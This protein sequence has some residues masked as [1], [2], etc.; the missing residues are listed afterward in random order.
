MTTPAG[1]GVLGVDPGSRWTAGVLRY[2]EAALYGW[3]VGPRDAA[4][5]RDRTA[6]DDADDV[7]AVSRYLARIVEM[8]DST[9]DRAEKVHGL[10]V[11]RLAVETIAV[12]IGYAKGGRRSSIAVVDWL[13]PRQVVI[14][15]LAVYPDARIVLPDA[16]GRAALDT[17]PVQLRRRRPPDWGPNE[18][19]RGERDHE[20]AAYDIAGVA[21]GMP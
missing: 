9:L 17:Y 11:L 21:A 4:G 12:P 6:L 1:M 2:G 18:T 14:G 15:V 19:V 3:T 20:R 5:D 7:A 10:T 8:I 13:V 16:H